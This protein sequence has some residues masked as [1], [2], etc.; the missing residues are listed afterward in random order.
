MHRI[1]VC[2][3]PLIQSLTIH[4]HHALNVSYL[5]CPTEM[6]FQIFD[7]IIH[8]GL[9][10]SR[11]LLAALVVVSVSKDEPQFIAFFQCLLSFLR[12]SQSLKLLLIY[13]P[14]GHWAEKSQTA[15]TEVASLIR[16]DSHKCLY[17]KN[18]SQ[19][20]PWATGDLKTRTAR[21]T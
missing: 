8:L 20:V 10:T 6:V 15:R 2:C 7:M 12:S 14:K 9:Q 21:G 16:L 1:L 13:L 17:Q 5:K 4:I 18:N 3:V 11:R 19:L